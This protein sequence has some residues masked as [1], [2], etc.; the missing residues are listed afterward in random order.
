LLPYGKSQRGLIAAAK[1]SAIWGRVAAIKS[2][3]L[4]KPS[5]LVALISPPERTESAIASVSRTD[6]KFGQGGRLAHASGQR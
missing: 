1:Q 2:I 3:T 4:L 6:G 5:A